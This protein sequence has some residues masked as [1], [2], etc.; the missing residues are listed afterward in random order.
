[1]QLYELHMHR[2]HIGV[3]QRYLVTVSKPLPVKIHPGLVICMHWVGTEDYIRY[4]V[5][6]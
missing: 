6:L 1:M 3:M 2:K 4:W 5:D